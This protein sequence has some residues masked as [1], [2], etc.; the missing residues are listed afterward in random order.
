MVLPWWV[1][2]RDA[3]CA[4]SHDNR[5]LIAKLP[6]QNTTPNISRT[7]YYVN[8]DPGYGNGTVVTTNPDGT[9]SFTLDITNQPIGLTMVGVRS[10]DANGA[11]SHDNRWMIAKLPQQNTTPNIT[12]TEYYVNNDPGYGNGTAVTSNP[13]GTGSFMLDITNQPIGL[14]MVGIRSRDANGAWSH[15]NRWLIAKLSAE[16]VSRPVKRVEYYIDTDPGYGKGNA[17]AIEETGNLP[18]RI[19]NA[20]ISGLATGKHYI[21]YRTQDKL[22]AWSH[23]NVDSFSLSSAH[24]APVLVVNSI[25]KSIF[26]ASDSLKIGYQETGSYTGAN[27][28]K[29]FVS[30]ANGSFANE[31]EIGTVSSVNN[32]ILYCKLPDHL[33]EG[34][35]YK[36]RIKSSSPVLTGETSGYSLAIHDRPYA[37]TITGDGNVNQGYSY[38]YNVPDATGSTWAW[39][40]PA[41]TIT[42]T[43]NSASLLWNT[44]GQPQTI[45]IVETNQ[46]GCVGDTS[47][48]NVNVYP[49]KI[50]EV[51]PS[52]CSHAP[53]KI[54]PWRQK[55]QACIMREMCLRHN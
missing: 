49:L 32:G 51:T 12:R 19:I 10:R 52:T 25:T 31:V 38:P 30:D 14:T 44:V 5:W 2:S 50:T 13:D 20:N 21:F 39:T 46:Y 41:A 15:D 33:Q 35:G 18:N 16:N 1:L 43:T 40:A 34:S 3:N 6:Q 48:K 26:R 9:G 29:A 7:E 22:G 53:P 27:T 37:Q 4:W 24:A 36:I 23:D 54:L 28:F 11:W 45:K 17:I 42:Q 55:H 8:N 47:S